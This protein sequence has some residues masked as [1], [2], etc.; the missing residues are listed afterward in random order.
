MRVGMR[1]VRRLVVTPEFWREEQQ[2]GARVFLEKRKPD[3]S[4]FRRR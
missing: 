4:R 3:F 1:G 2:E